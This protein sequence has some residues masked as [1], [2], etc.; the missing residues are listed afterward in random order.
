[1]DTMDLSIVIP[2]DL[3]RRSWDIYKRIKLFVHTFK[4]S[5]IQLLLGCNNKPTFWINRLK[6]LVH[7]YSNIQLCL[8]NAQASSL[9]KLRNTAIKEIKTKFVLFLDIDI[10]PD[11]HIVSSIYNIY[12]QRENTLGM[13][14]CLYL[15]RKGSKKLL[16]NS[17]AQY[18]EHY[19]DFRRDLILHI[20]FPS[21]IIFTDTKSVQAIC[22]FD[23][24]YIGHGYE[25]FDFI[26]RLFEYKKIIQLTEDVLIDEPY[27]APL[28]SSGL[29]ALL[30]KPFLEVLLTD[31]Y[32]LHVFHKK[33]KNESYYQLR[34][35]NKSLFL[36]KFKNKDLAKYKLKKIELIQLFFNL[37]NIEKNSQKYAVLW[38]EIKGYQLR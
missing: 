17:T 18:I 23:E 1:M 21:S 26:L 29:R 15:S 31:H 12:N 19:F 33:D 22:G 6:K 11:I 3:N 30:A 34:Q 16:K 38:A 32:F 36:N 28:M 20:A 8:V 27:L 4:N 9:S 24:Q 10:F 25:D 13:F 14:P 35:N 37:P 5:N 2:I 7:P